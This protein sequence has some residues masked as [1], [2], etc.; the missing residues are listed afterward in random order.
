MTG[1]RGSSS[2]DITRKATVTC[3]PAASGHLQPQDDCHSTTESRREHYPLSRFAPLL[4]QTAK[5]LLQSNAQP[6]GG[7][8]HDVKSFIPPTGRR[9]LKQL[10]LLPRDSCTT[11]RHGHRQS[12]L[13]VCQGQTHNPTGWCLVTRAG[14]VQ[15]EFY[16]APP[17]PTAAHA[18]YA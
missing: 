14:A 12:P 4:E 18:A 16:R 1:G 13:S 8:G 3:Q 5:H 17:P 7:Q 10:C 9:R 6:A 15:A 11:S 2:T